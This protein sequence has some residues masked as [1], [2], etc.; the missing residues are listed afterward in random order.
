MGGN[1]DAVIARYAAVGMEYGKPAL[2]MPAEGLM[3]KPEDIKLKPVAQH[4]SKTRAQGQLAIA[5]SSSRSISKTKGKEKAKS[6]S[7]GPLAEFYAEAGAQAEHN[8]RAGVRS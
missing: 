6:G 7:E 1:Y 8:G 3:F 4:K 5:S 2:K